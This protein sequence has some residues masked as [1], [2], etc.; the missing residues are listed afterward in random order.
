MGGGTK[1]VNVC[2]SAFT[3]VISTGVYE[4]TVALSIT[5][6]DR[7]RIEFA[8]LARLIVSSEKSRS[9]L[10]LTALLRLRV[11]CVLGS[12]AVRF[13]VVALGGGGHIWQPLTAPPLSTYLPV[14]KSMCSNDIPHPPAANSQ[15]SEFT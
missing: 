2:E 5:T 13:A 11:L 7:F 14:H 15:K 9:A 10:V 4:T 12:R 6:Y 3:C 1:H 8:A